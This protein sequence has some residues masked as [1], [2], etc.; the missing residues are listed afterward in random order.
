M[1]KFLILFIFSHILSISA[2]NKIPSKSELDSVMLN[3]VKQFNEQLAGLKIDEYTNIKYV[4]YDKNPPLFTYFYTTTALSYL[5]KDSLDQAQKDAMRKFN[6]PKT[7]SSQMKPLMK[8]YNLKVDHIF[9]DK[10]TGKVIYKLTVSHL[11]C[12]GK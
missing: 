5:K 11:D 9:E 2:E 6:I 3:A 8:P 1:K 10:N 4:T 12:E 7:C